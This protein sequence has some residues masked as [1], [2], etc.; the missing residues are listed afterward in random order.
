MVIGYRVYGCEME[1][2]LGTVT[3]QGYN[4][5]RSTYIREMNAPDKLELR[6]TWI[7]AHTLEKLN[8]QKLELTC[9]KENSDGQ[10]QSE[11][12]NCISLIVLI[13]DTETWSLEFPSTENKWGPCGGMVHR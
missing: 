9:T 13:E 12:R 8:R 6:Q 10:T 3:I 7:E 1:V 2:V 4:L 11:E 5:K